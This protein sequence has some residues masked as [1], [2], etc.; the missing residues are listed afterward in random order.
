MPIDIADESEVQT[1][2]PEVRRLTDF[3]FRELGI[4]ESADLSVLFVDEDQMTALHEQWLDEPGPT[5]VISIPMDEIREPGLGQPPVGG[6]LGDVIV[7]PAVAARQADAAGHETIDEIRILLTHGV[8]HLLGNDH[9][10]PQE[11]QAMF[12]RQNELIARYRLNLDA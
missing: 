6:I 12:A 9:A 2:E 4:A 5:D 7:C 8:L 1:D 10:D 3:L 11:A